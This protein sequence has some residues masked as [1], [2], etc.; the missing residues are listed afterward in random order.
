MTRA[1]F[2]LMLNG[3]RES[4][5]NRVSVVVAVFALM[6]LLS[7][8]LV[9]EVT[10]YTFK[11]VLTDVGLGAMGITLVLLAI[12][13]S[14]SQLSREIERKTIFLVVSKPVSRGLFL[15]AR[16]AGTLLTLA[17]LLV[18]MTTVFFSQLALYGIPITLPQLLGA[19]MLLIELTVICSVGFLMSS[20]AGHVV[21]AVVTVGVYFAG[22]LSADVYSFSARSESALVVAVGKAVYYLLPNLDRVNYR[23]MASH[24]V[25]IP[26]AQTLEAIAYAIGYAGVMLSLSVLVFSRRDFK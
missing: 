18:L 8:T 9:T 10:V 24:D 4:R 11:R 6:L 13:L 25:L 19:A 12:F 1:F 22:H 16:F 15:C 7:S 20:F 2:A 3:F 5:R 17:V 26:S 14:S 23:P 21:S